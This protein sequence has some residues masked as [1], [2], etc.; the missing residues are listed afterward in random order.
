MLVRAAARLEQD[1]ASPADGGATFLGNEIAVVANDR[2]AAPRTAAAESALVEA[3]VT[4]GARLFGGAAVDIRPLAE[5]DRLGFTLAT[6]APA[7]L[8]DL[9]SR[10]D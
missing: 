1:T 5:S 8:A 2:L 7:S 10:V 9:S 4:L 3:L 6:G